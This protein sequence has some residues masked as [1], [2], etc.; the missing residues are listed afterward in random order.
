MNNTTHKVN[1]LTEAH[2]EFFNFDMTQQ[3][4]P[5]DAG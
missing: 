4:Q 2:T 5:L 3:K 1:G